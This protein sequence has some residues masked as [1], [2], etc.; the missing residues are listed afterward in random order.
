M[1]VAG[2]SG[3]VILCFADGFRSRLP[4]AIM[5]DFQPSRLGSRLRLA[6][7]IVDSNSQSDGVDVI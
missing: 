2:Q 5:F 6:S 4:V 1:C 7:F 3:A